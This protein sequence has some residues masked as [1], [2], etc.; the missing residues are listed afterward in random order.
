VSL[1]DDITAR[2][3]E[4]RTRVRD[5]LE[6]HKYPG[7]IKTH[8]L[9][10]YVDIALEH[11]KAIWLLKDAKLNGS[12]FALVRPVFDTML[13]AHWVNKVATDEQIE[14]VFNDQLKVRMPK[15]YADFK[16]AYFDSIPPEEAAVSPETAD[17]FLQLLDHIWKVTSS[18]THSGG[19]QLGRRFQPNGALKPNYSEADTAQALSSA[20]VALLLLVHMFFV[21]VGCYEEME[22]V[23]TLLRQSHDD[24][25]ERLGSGQ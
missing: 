11:H 7:D 20:T 5:L 18:Y 16:R 17:K 2:G 3:V 6:R 8:A 24:F 19:L 4:V 10:G 21:S 15:L 22:D 25:K 12:A 1:L 9:V 23:R 13:R 14:Q